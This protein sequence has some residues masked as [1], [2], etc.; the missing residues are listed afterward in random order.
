MK[1]HRQRMKIR[2]GTRTGKKN[3]RR[4]VQMAH[5]HETVFGVQR[6]I[7]QFWSAERHS[8]RAEFPYFGLWPNGLRVTINTHFSIFSQK[9]VFRF[10]S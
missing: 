3:P 6:P 2:L 9:D 7:R 4:K 1:N 5:E 10:T 8:K